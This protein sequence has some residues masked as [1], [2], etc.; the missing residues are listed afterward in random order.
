MKIHVA[1]VIKNSEGEVLFIQ[2]SLKKKSLPG[3][4]SFASG[5][6]EEGEEYFQTARREAMEELGIEINPVKILGE[7]NLD[8]FS[9]KLV[10]VLCEIINGIPFV[11]Q[12]EEI[13]KFEWM[14]FDDFF[15]RFSDDKIG[16]GLIWLRKNREILN[17][18]N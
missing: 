3:A 15:A 1:L 16:H 18:I 2:R 6:V 10:F 4:W 12:S 13:E 7:V 9:V 17:E 5:T 11:K 14:G 8:E